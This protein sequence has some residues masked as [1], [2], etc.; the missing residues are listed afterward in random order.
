MLVQALKLAFTEKKYILVALAAALAVFIFGTWLPNLGLIWQIVFMSSVSVP[1]KLQVLVALIGSIATNF[2]VFSAISM[3]AIALLFGTNL[4]MILFLL[5]LRRQFVGQGGGV[6]SVG[7]L[8][9]GIFG[10]G[11]AACG[12]F[13][14]GPL[15]SFAGASTVIAFLP[16]GGHEFSILGLGMLGFSLFLIAKKICTPT[17]CAVGVP[18]KTGVRRGSQE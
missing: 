2:T 12:T 10:I 6:A 1:D 17:A 9:S 18:N 8:A 4:A 7:G 15:L 11:C 3:V 16:F 14:L 13:V 5:R